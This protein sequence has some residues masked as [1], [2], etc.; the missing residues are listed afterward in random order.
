MTH[1]EASTVL[2]VPLETLQAA[3][4][5]VEDWTAFIVGVSKITKRAHERY[6][7]ELGEDDR[8]REVPTVVRLNHRDHCFTWHA[9][10]GPRF[11]GCLRLAALDGHRTRVTLEITEHPHG[12]MGNLTDLVA[13]DRRHAALDIQRLQSYAAR[14]AARA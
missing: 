13:H 11:E 10:S 7:F 3:L 2:T 8:T 1:Q 5:N 6:V 12:F 9:V 4:R 14:A